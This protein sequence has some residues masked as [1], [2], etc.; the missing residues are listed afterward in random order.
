MKRYESSTPRAALG[1]GAVAMAAITIAG[2]VVLPAQL[3]SVSAEPYAVAASTRVAVESAITTAP[4]HAP[5]MAAHRE[6][7]RFGCRKFDAQ[8]HPRVASISG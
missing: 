8:A 5:E 4:S 3:N 1:L 2:L 7:A 6:H